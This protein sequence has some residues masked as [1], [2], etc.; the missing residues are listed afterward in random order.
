MERSDRPAFTTCS[1]DHCD[2][3]VEPGKAALD[4]PI[5]VLCA[6]TDHDL[7]L[8]QSVAVGSPEPAVT[9]IRSQETPSFSK[10]GNTISCCSANSRTTTKERRRPCRPAPRHAFMPSL[11]MSRSSSPRPPRVER[12]L[13]QPP[14]P[15]L[16]QFRPHRPLA[17][18]CH[19]EGT[20]RLPGIRDH[21]RGP[22]SA[23]ARRWRWTGVA[24]TPDP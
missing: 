12:A 6:I 7:T 11:V 24:R 3:K 8:P 2:R 14:E 17:V 15:F 13:F 23:G 10:F 16:E 9:R 20:T 19:E 18:N 22:L 21:P 5:R 4:H 1:T